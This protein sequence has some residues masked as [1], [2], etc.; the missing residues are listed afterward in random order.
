MA[1]PPARSIGA[2]EAVALLL[3]EIDAD[4]P[5]A[6]LL[7]NVLP[8]YRV[9]LADGLFHV[10]LFDVS[11]GVLYTLTGGEFEPAASPAAP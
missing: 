2:A 7:W 6:A 1:L 10:L 11:P 8:S 4:P 3:D 9:L 5:A